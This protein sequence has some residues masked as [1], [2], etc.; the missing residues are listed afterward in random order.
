VGVG[1]AL[2]LA[3]LAACSPDRPVEVAT[4]KR[5]TANSEPVTT[6]PPAP[7]SSTTT[8]AASPTSAATTG[9]RATT[10]TVPVT[11]TTR[12]PDCAPAPHQFGPY[13]FD[14]DLVDGA[15]G[16]AAGTRTIWVTTDGGATW[17]AACLPAGAQF[18]HALAVRGQKAW[19]AGIGEEGGS[20]FILRSTDGG[21]VWRLA[22]VPAGATYLMDIAFPDDDHGWVVGRRP[23]TDPAYGDQYG[24]G[25][26][27]LRSTDGGATWTLSQDFPPD[28]AGGLSVS[29]SPT[30]TTAG[31]RAR[32][33]ATPP[34]CWPPPTAGTPGGPRRFRPRSGRS[35]TCSSS[36]GTGAGSPPT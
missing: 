32:P 10:A 16:F 11:T 34:S 17:T 27:L 22:Q 9:P 24:G 18:V 20:A 30:P 4:G 1:A 8:A 36:T 19:A 12:G 7:A 13:V 2:V 15:L 14:A 26:L 6:S 23:Q 5:A 31:F 29:A 33:G 21:R 3:A 28:V 25:A 35:T